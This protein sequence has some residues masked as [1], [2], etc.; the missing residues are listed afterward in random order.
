M[1]LVCPISLRRIHARL[2]SQ[3]NIY[4][5]SKSEGPQNVIFESPCKPKWIERKKYETLSSSSKNFGSQKT[6]KGGRRPKAAAPLCMFFS[7]PKLFRLVL[8]VSYFFL[9]ILFGLQR[10][11]KITFCGP[12]TYLN[13]H[14]Y[15]LV[16]H[17]ALI[18][19]FTLLQVIKITCCRLLKSLILIT[20]NRNRF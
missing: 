19:F 3:R 2:K 6:Y 9:S 18:F 13:I 5:L 8:K 4:S 16:W 15:S 14:L 20:C 17:S 11:S 7:D 1:W 10:L 12:W